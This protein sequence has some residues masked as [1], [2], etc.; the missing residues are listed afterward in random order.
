MNLPD[1]FLADLPP[2][3]AL[4][5]TMLNEACLTLK[6]NRLRYLADRPTEHLVRLLDR[7]AANWLQPNHRF[8]RLALELG[9][10]QTGFSRATLATG[11]DGF[12]RQV[13][14]DNLHALLAQ[15]L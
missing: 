9:P 7:V 4:T 3:A 13:T 8:R 14:C 12:F 11:L 1:Y 6:R 15:D 2:E 10:A 5:P